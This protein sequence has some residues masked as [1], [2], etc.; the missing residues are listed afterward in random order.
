MTTPQ[1][2]RST[3]KRNRPQTIP[4]D[5]P[6]WLSPF[7]AAL[8]VNS[9]TSTLA[10]RRLTGGGPRYCRIG[11]AIRYSRQDLDEWLNATARRS[12]SDTGDGR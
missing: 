1:A 2:A 8:Y 7:E 11:R 4:S 10:K 6:D 5:W 12:T 9:S 3:G